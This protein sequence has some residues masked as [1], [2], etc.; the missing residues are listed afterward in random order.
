MHLSTKRHY[1]HKGKENI[2]ETH[3]LDIPNRHMGEPI[4]VV[5]EQL[6]KFLAFRVGSY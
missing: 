6:L 4:T 2:D 3:L 5:L 1:R